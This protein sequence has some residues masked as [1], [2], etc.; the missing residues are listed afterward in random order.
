MGALVHTCIKLYPEEE[1]SGDRVV[2]SPF[3][4]LLNSVS[5]EHWLF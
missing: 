1:V 4:H 3:F 5:L 2:S